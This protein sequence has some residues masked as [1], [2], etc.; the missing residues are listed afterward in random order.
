MP[1]EPRYSESALSK[2]TPPFPQSAGRRDH[3]DV[4]HIELDQGVHP[5]PSD[6]APFPLASVSAWD[7][8]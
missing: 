7:H 8:A 4:P 3:Q 6:I 5:V 1:N 2:S